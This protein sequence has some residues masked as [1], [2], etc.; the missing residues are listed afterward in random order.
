MFHDTFKT[1]TPTRKQRDD[2]TRD[3]FRILSSRPAESHGSERR[4]PTLDRSS[5]ASTPPSLFVHTSPPR[6]RGNIHPEG[7]RSRSAAAT[8]RGWP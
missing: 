1:T 7:T 6:I 3:S 4:M 8:S 2:G 5:S